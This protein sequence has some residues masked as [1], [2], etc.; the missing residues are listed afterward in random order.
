MA[1]HNSMV[2]I[3]CYAAPIAMEITS[4]SLDP[5]RVAQHP[6]LIST[7]EIRDCLTFCR[8]RV[9]DTRAVRRRLF[10]RKEGKQRASNH[11][12]HHN[13]LGTILPVHPVC[14][15]LCRH[16]GHCECMGKA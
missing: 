3:C 14:H 1:I 4:E 10:C 16:D 2:E 8:A 15:G 7:I 13:V 5:H 11:E 6:R 9:T 12:K